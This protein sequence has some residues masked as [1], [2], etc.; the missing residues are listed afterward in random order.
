MPGELLDLVLDQI[1]FLF[2]YC[3]QELLPA[4]GSIMAIKVTFRLYTR[5]GMY[6]WLSNIV[7]H[8]QSNNY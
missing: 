8:D 7:I 2:S 5:A 4:F 6:N 1:L 3:Q